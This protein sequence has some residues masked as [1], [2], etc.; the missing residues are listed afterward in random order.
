MDSMFHQDQ[1]L[2][3]MIDEFGVDGIILSPH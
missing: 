2:E 3:E 1:M